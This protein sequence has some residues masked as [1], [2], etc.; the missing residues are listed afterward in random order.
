MKAHDSP[1]DQLSVQQLRAF[2]L[3]FERQSFTAA[4]TEMGLSAPTIWEQVRALEGRYG[5]VLFERRGRRIQPTPVAGLLFESL[6]PLLAGVD[7]TFELLR[8]AGGDHPR[9]LTLVTGAR[10]ML[11]DL[12]PALKQ[13]QKRFPQVALR[14]MHG[15]A[16]AAE[17]LVVAGAADLALTLEPGPGGAGRGVTVE[18]AYPIDYLALIPK[19]HRLAG[20]AALSLRALVGYPLVVGHSGTYGRQLLQQALHREGLLGRARI[21]AETDTSAF[22]IAC[23][24]AGM[25]L[26][27][28]AGRPAGF[29]TRDLVA[30]TLQPQL[31]QAWIALLWK[32]GQL[33]S[34]TVQAL[35]ELVR[36]L[37]AVPSTKTNRLRGIR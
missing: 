1:A 17:D 30:R 36:G 4:A 29:L 5:G 2:C 11:E 9:G 15:N 6:K 14:L 3:V 10:M 19:R 35:I 20:G 26:G 18:R 13:F 24:R 28:V 7:S 21:V 8:E 12:G 16:K 34:Q 32:K 22:T 37:R 31:G 25:G 27:V 33:L 23:V